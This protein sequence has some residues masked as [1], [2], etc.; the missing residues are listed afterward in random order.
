MAIDDEIRRPVA[1]VFRRLTVKR[2]QSS[3]G[4]FES[5]WQDLSSYVKSWG[6]VRSSADDVR[7]NRFQH[8]GITLTCRNDDGA[9][10]PE[11]SSRSFWSGYLTRYRTLV[12]VEAG[13]LTDSGTELPTDSTQGIFVLDNEIVQDTAGNQVA[14]QCSSLRSIF[15]EVR[16]SDISG[17]GATAS[18]A[19][20]LALVR[21]HTDGSSRFVFRQF[22]TS[23]SWSI[24]SGTANYNFATTT[25]LDGMSAWDLMEK[26]A[27]AEGY[28]LFITRTG[29][30]TFR[31][32]NPA[33]TA[34]QHAFYGQDFPRQNVLKVLEWK[35]GLNRYYNYFRLK[36]AEGDTSTSYV[37]A[38]TM[39]TVDPANTV[40]KYGSRPY[41][42]T[43]T[44]VANQ[45]AATSLVNAQLSTFGTIKDEYRILAKFTPHVDIAD[46]VD[47]SHHSY[48]LGPNTRWDAF[49]WDGANWASEGES[50]DWNS[51]GASV[52]SRK[53]DLDR[54]TTEFYL[55][56]T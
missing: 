34:S 19:A 21:D 20:L 37:S 54:F 36:F 17:L 28:I 18:A 11:T 55:R 6:V 40:W 3:D 14:L 29:G 8:A 5:S 32:R 27:E 43:N 31:D 47:L 35:E 9:F 52:L 13:Y 23:T 2:R 56:G 24:Q 30:L 48:P 50:I 44:F 51:V 7:I 38:G 4:L 16:A 12:R 22:I 41:N 1:S 53:T 49:R 10:A 42:Y 15:D 33:T 25:S 45:S 46:R 26:I 39:T